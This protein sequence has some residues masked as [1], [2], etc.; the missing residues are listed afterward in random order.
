MFL[1]GAALIN[2]LQKKQLSGGIFACDGNIL[3]FGE[4]KSKC[5]FLGFSNQSNQTECACV[6]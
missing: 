4:K 5:W 6:K 1:W 2:P 3:S